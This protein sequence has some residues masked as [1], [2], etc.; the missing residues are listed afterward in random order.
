[1]FDS[2]QWFPAF[3]SRR[4]DDVALY[5]LPDGRRIPLT[6]PE[7]A[8][9]EHLIEPVHIAVPA[10][11]HDPRNPPDLPS[12]IVPHYVPDLHPD[13]CAVVDGLP[14]TSVSRTLIDMAEEVDEPELRVLFANAR[15]R[16]MLDAAAMHASRA[17]VEWRPSLAM[18]DRVIADF[19]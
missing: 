12:W 3:D 15:E 17:R 19:C 13:D 16:G 5:E 1:M 4:T 7:A 14:C 11:A 2:S 18:L 6:G 9:Y 8:A 10:S